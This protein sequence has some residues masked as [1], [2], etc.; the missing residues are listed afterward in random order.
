ML[1]PTPDDRR[2][3]INSS[4][5]YKT[6]RVTR[7]SMSSYM[8]HKSNLNI[9]GELEVRIS[10][11]E[12]NNRI[13]KLGYD[14]ILE[15][16]KT[17]VTEMFL[18]PRR[19]YAK[20]DDDWMS[21]FGWRYDGEDVRLC[22]MKVGGSFMLNSHKK[23]KEDCASAIAKIIMYG[24]TNR[25]ADRL[26]DYIEKNV[27]YSQNIIY[28]LENR[29][30]YWFFKDGSKVECRINMQ[31][32]DEDEIAIEIS[33]GVWGS[34]GMKDANIFINCY[35]SNSTR[36]KKWSN[37]SP[38]KLFK[39]VMGREPSESE[40]K[41]MIAWLMQNRTSKMVEER[42]AVLLK[43]MTD[44]YDDMVLL[45]A[46][47]TKQYLGLNL[48]EN[49][50]HAVLVRGRLGDWIIYANNQNSKFQ[51]VSAVIAYEPNHEGDSPQFQGPFCI[52]NLHDN[53]SIGDQIASRA[54]ILKNDI[55]A[56]TMI[57]TLRSVRKYD[58][59]FSDDTLDQIA[60]NGQ[61]LE[62]SKFIM[63]YIKED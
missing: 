57:H 9:R 52:D 45:D 47:C 46:E 7:Y 27:K 20:E 4:F 43:E 5:L 44:K 50:E 60:V 16:M 14:P 26:R 32:I 35:R 17:K 55:Q 31:L 56:R 36:S 12:I 62:L 30:P 58:F 41:L 1:I 28:A 34:M 10:R 24:T 48:S 13:N 37:L 38:K 42:A 8:F 61:F 39:A 59:R 51:R 15:R 2:E 49:Y 18:S 63:Q 3:T 33:D 53:S 6:G 23:N 22:L 40:L 19:G 29:T 11:P 54:M 25:S 21:W